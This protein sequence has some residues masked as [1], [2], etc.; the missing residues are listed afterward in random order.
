VKCDGEIKF[1]FSGHYFLCSKKVWP[2][3]HPNGSKKNRQNSYFSMIKTFKLGIEE[4][5]LNQIRNINEKLTADITVNS[6]RL[7]CPKMKNII[8]SILAIS[9]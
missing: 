4:N 6:E 1:L 8:G 7:L 5:F 9:I 3:D 2:H